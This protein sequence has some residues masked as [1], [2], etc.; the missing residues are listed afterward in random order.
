MKIKYLAIAAMLSLPIY[1]TANSDV[2]AYCDQYPENCFVNSNAKLEASNA[3]EPANTGTY[4]ESSKYCDD[5]PSK[6]VVDKSAN[7]TKAN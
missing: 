1:A 7:L 3:N 5:N 2:D 4:G 6:C